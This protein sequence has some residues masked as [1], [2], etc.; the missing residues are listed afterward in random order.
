M[1]ISGRALGDGQPPYIIAELGVNHDGSVERALMMV[2]SAAA[3]GADAVKLQLF[4]ADLLMS[5]SAQLAAYQRAAGESD[6]LMMLRRLELSIE[7]MQ[8]IVARAHALHLHAI[9]TVFSVELVSD[10]ERLPW[11]AYKSA[12]PDIVHR[13]LLESLM[14]TGRPLIVSTGASELDE[15]RRA[16]GWLADA[17]ER[18]ALLQCVSSYPTPGE[19]AAIGAIAELAPLVATVGYSD[20]TDQI[21]T[22]ALA[23]RHGALVLE[24]H[25]THDRGATGPDHA[26]SLDAAG[27]RA[28]VDAARRARRDR[29]ASSLNRGAHAGGGPSDPR[30]GDGRKRVQECERDVRGASRQSIVVVRD[31]APGHIIARGDLTF[32]RPGT[33]LLPFELD[34]VVGRT[35]ARAVES[36]TPI[37]L[38]DLRPA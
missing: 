29:L 37:T 8:P 13:P 24:K 11:D 9:V 3:A 10:A 7:Q 22:G 20:H 21:D 32:K 18:L 4:K 27:F 23:V 2:E 17:R 15:V 14:R 16:V 5:R 25:L 35:L 6:P 38:D 19:L 30:L 33:G 36:D 1:N 31:L 12:S 34:R 28:Y 26:A